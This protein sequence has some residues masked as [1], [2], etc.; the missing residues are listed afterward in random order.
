MKS[1]ERVSFTISLL[2]SKKTYFSAD[3][4]YLQALVY[5]NSDPADILSC[6]QALRRALK[7]EPLHQESLVLLASLHFKNKE[8]MPASE[9][10]SLLANA[11]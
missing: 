9:A 3:L 2:N 7:E 1:W 6:E 11:L 8:V 4:A 5:L 10:E